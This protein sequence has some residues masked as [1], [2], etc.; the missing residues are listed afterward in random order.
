MSDTEE[1]RLCQDDF[2]DI[3]PL[4]RK[5][6]ALYLKKAEEL[7]EW[8]NVK[9]AKFRRTPYEMPSPNFMTDQKARDN[10]ATLKQKYYDSYQPPE[11]KVVTGFDVYFVTYAWPIPQLLDEDKAIKRFCPFGENKEPPQHPVN[12]H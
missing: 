8:E 12:D 1:L 5:M 4:T 10:Y 3:K 7:V 2:I 6:A 9:C 11:G